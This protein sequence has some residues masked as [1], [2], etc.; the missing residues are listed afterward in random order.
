MR[1]RRERSIL[2]A[3]G[4]SL[5][6]VPLAAALW[7]APDVPAWTLS[8]IAVA[9]V[10][11]VLDGWVVRRARREAWAGGDPGAYAAHVARGEVID[12]L[13]DKIFVASAVLALL[14]VAH[15]PWWALGA[16][17]AR[18]LLLVPALSI[19]RFLPAAQRG[20]VDF[21][22]GYAGKAATFFQLAGLVAGFLGSALFVP[23]A[24]LAGALGALAAILYVARAARA[25]RPAEPSA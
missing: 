9:G 7:I 25:A 13:A 1:A 15:P 12:G 6:R 21:T 11:D 14:A 19:Y 5:S 10:T 18:E 3:N 24:V 17:V 23:A 16:L 2:L 22:A 20:K 4:L 8:I